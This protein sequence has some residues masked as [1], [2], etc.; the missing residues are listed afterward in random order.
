MGE[1]KGEGLTD[2]D[3]AVVGASC[4]GLVAARH[5]AEAGMRTL[6]FDARDS[7]G[8]PERTWIVTPKI[9]RLLDVD[10]SP[11]VVHRTG[12]MELRAGECRRRVALDDPDFIVERAELRR[13]LA[14]EAE[15]SG[16]TIELR[17]RVQSVES[18]PEGHLVRL[19][20]NGNG[21]PSTVRARHLIGA[22]GVKSVVAEWLGAP[23]NRTVPIVQARVLLPDGHDPDVTQVWFDRG[24]TRF[25]YWLIP[26]SN[27]TG[28]LGLIAERSDN[29]R[30]LLDEFLAER[31]IE[32]IEYQGAMIPLHQPRR[33]V[34]W[35]SK[36]ARVL[37]V[38]DAAAHVKVT[39]VGGVVSGIWG[40]TA[41]ARA[42]VHGTG[43]GRELGPLH[44][45]LWLHDAVRWLMDRF[46]DHHYPRLLGL[47]NEGL[48]ELLGKHDRDSYAST[49][50]ALFKAQPRLA[51]L[52]LDVLG[53]P[54]NARRRIAG[55]L[56][57]I[58]EDM[59]ECNETTASEVTTR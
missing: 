25:F 13:I 31:D 10:L 56:G 41:A 5:T 55:F 19:N 44:R 18:Y 12:V 2:V 21:V 35:G 51:L 47:L 16:A 52:A 4:A 20:G 14:R 24:R 46:H 27:T 30:Q 7:F 6:V 33:R 36:T 23:P 11:S 50:W 54:R 26:E 40:A 49:A 22:D 59:A 37:L 34:E 43:Y 38:G 42:L 45:E 8:Q 58:E 48:H 3:V 15:S 57:R 39:T 53:H 32:P 17:H 28:V 1:T 29:A 9:E